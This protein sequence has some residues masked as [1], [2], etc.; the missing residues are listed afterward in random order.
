M[1]EVDVKQQELDLAEQQI[2]TDIFG[3]YTPDKFIL[4]AGIFKYDL[5]GKVQKVLNDFERVVKPL[6]NDEGQINLA[7]LRKYFATDFINLPEGLYRPIELYRKIQPLVAG[8][9]DY[10]LGVRV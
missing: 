3:G 2:L 4:R 8:L 1:T 7:E 9:K 6:M 10:I 5:S